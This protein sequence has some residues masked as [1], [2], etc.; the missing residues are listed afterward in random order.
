ME[1]IMKN[2]LIV[3]VLLTLGNS[4]FA[5][6]RITFK[7]QKITDLN[8][9]MGD[10]YGG[11]GS[12]PSFP[13]IWKDFDAS[14]DEYTFTGYYSIDPKTAGTEMPVLNG[15]VKLIRYQIQMA[16]GTANF[17]EELTFNFVDGQM[18]GP[19]SFYSYSAE[20]DGEQDEADLKNTQ[21]TK[22]LGLVANYS[23]ADASYKNINYLKTN[24][25]ERT[26]YIIIQ[27]VG[28]DI[29]L[30]YFGTIIGLNTSPPNQKPVFKKLKY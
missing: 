23:L 15:E 11:D 30:D 8:V 4:A 10:M 2:V 21:W 20:Y 3:L 7:A 1:C 24:D 29:S 16:E 6:K 17:K 5:Q 19:V 22:D 18:S 28:Y 25:Y 9:A 26:K 13:L 27:A 12:T 14:S